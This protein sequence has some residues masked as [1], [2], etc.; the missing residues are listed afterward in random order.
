MLE[1]CLHVAYKKF[2]TDEKSLVNNSVDVT[3]KAWTVFIR[4]KNIR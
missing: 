4:Q 2:D 3:P 1:E